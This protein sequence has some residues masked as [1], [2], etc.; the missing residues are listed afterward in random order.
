MMKQPA[1]NTN[2]TAE[3][4]KKVEERRRPP[5]QNGPE[6]RERA[7]ELARRLVGNQKD[8]DPSIKARAEE[9]LRNQRNAQA[10]P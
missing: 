5:A 2:A 10:K 3:E 9:L 6:D 4:T 8:P 7:D 1:E